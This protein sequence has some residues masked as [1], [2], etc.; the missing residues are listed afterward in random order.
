MF[1]KIDDADDDDNA[2]NDGG[3]DN[4]KNDDSDEDEDD[5]TK[6]VEH[7]VVLLDVVHPVQLVVD[8]SAGDHL[9]AVCSVMMMMIML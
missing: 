4:D 3:D 9:V 5:L 1:L 7:P 2:D 6:D 8:R